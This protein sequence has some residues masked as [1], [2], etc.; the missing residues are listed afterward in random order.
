[1]VSANVIQRTFNIRRGESQG[2]AFTIDRAGRQYLVTARHVVESIVPG[3]NISVWHEEQ[4]KALDVNVVGVGE[5]EVD[6]AVLAP[7]FQISPMHL[8][9][10][11]GS[12]S[13][14]YGQQ[15]YILGFPHG[16]DSG[17]AEINRGLPI[18][19]VKSGVISAFA[20][21]DVK[22]IYIDTHAN[23]GFSGGPVV[24]R[25]QQGGRDP[26]ELRVAGVITGYLQY[27]RALHD[28]DGNHLANVGENTGIAVAVGVQHATDLID[29]NQI[30]FELPTG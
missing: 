27:S 24:F 7:P 20:F 12:G 19:F 18:P 14:Y 15:V 25:P 21:G 8:L 28:A 6:V 13:T 26:H 10:A 22:K 16:H 30:G 4:W 5:G 29:A 11:A 9:E 23:E 3:E 1:M 17:G 2:T